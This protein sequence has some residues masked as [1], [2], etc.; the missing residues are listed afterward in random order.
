MRCGIDSIR[1]MSR[2]I[3]DPGAKPSVVV[4]RIAS[5]A[6]F[7][8]RAAFTNAAEHVAPAFATGVLDLRVIERAERRVR[9]DFAFDLDDFALPP[10][11]VAEVSLRP[12]VC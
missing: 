11:F 10:C 8:P 4:L 5:V 1:S 7:R 9:D 2:K 12:H 6:S 3:T